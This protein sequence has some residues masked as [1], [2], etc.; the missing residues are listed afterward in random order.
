MCLPFCGRRSCEAHEQ[1]AKN[2][3]RFGL[4]SVSQRIPYCRLDGHP[5]SHACFN[6][7]LT[8]IRSDTNFNGY[9]YI[10]KE[11]RRNHFCATIRSHYLGC[12]GTAAKAALVVARFLFSLRVFSSPLQHPGRRGVAE[13]LAPRRRARGLGLHG[14]PPLL[15]LARRRVLLL[16]D[17][18][19]VA[20]WEI[21]LCRPNCWRANW[22]S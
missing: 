13:R 12:H 6:E 3:S 15:R 5:V 22:R 21:H 20:P 11:K 19:A 10:T 18:V 17:R 16:G 4:P 8:L 7:G 9:K 14:P 1:A 2:G